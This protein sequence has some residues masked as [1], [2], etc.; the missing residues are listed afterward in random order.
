MS[1][2]KAKRFWTRTHLVEEGGGF[3][4]RLDDRPV[5]TPGKAPLVVPSRG[6]GDAIVAEWDAQV[7]EIN[8]NLMPLTRAANSAI[9]KIAVQRPDVVAMLAEYGATDLLCYRAEHPDALIRRQAEAW[10]PLLDWAG[11]ELAAPLTP[12]AGVMFHPQPD[13]SLARLTALVEAHDD[14]ELVALHD[15]I[16][17]SGSLVVGLAISKGRLDAAA[18]WPLTRIDETFQEEDWGVDEEAAALAER[19]RSDFLQAER[20][21]KLVREP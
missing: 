14:F 5:R 9:E 2:W 10:N 16:A 17:L 15:L 12:V 1:E 18:A 13:T 8:P 19:K 11:R 7:E 21:L 3:G 4:I 20:L 6:L